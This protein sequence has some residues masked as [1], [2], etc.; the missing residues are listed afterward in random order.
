MTGAEPE[1]TTG[2]SLL[3]LGDYEIVDSLA[4][5]GMAHVYLAR[6]GK[7]AGLETPV[8]VKRILPHLA[9]DEQFLNMFLDEARIVASL[10]HPNIVRIIEIGKLESSIARKREK[11]NELAAQINQLTDEISREEMQLAKL[12]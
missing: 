8:V 10:H 7:L 3:R 5:G 2:R 12:K 1:Y 11:A 9:R 4:T 6:H